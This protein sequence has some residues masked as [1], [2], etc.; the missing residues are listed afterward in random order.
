MP[1]EMAT[2]KPREKRWFDKREVI[3]DVIRQPHLQTLTERL[4]ETNR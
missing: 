2:C 3:E 1:L 4:Y